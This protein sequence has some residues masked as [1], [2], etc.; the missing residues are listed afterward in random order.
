MGTLA[1]G[2]YHH[3]KGYNVSQNMSTLDGIKEAGDSRCAH[4]SVVNL[5]KSACNRRSLM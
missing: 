2:Q 3:P 1:L 5:A 4:L